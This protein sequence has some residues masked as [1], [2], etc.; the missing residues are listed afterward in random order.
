MQLS[1]FK[2]MEEI[3]YEKLSMQEMRNIN[4]QRFSAEY[5]GL[6]ERW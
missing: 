1:Y 6:P 5:D 4:Q 3:D 2:Q